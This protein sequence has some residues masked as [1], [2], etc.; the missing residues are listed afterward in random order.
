MG[1]RRLEERKAGYTADGEGL[2]P[3]R[4]AATLDGRRICSGRRAA[5]IWE[6]VYASLQ[7]KDCLLK[8]SALEGAFCGA[9]ILLVIC[10]LKEIM[11]R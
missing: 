4:R 11:L 6:W 2:T 3:L 1:T 5:L 8:N 9:S 10:S 7:G